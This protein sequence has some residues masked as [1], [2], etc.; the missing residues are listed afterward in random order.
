MPR[1]A[2]TSSWPSP[3]NWRSST[4][5]AATGSSAASRV[6]GVVEGEELVVGVGGGRVGQLDPAAAAAP[7][8]PLL[9]AGVL[10]EDAAHGLG[11]RGEEVAAAVP[12]A[13]PG[14]APTS[15]RYASW[16]RAVAWSV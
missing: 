6:E 16:T 5:W 7:L 1:T 3:A 11:R 2:A 4:T 13:G 15:R 9:A 12:Q 14:R 10:D 8:Q